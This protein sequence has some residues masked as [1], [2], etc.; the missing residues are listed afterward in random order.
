MAQESNKSVIWT[1]V[2][3]VVLAL[4]LLGGFA[5]VNSNVKDANDKADAAVTAAN[6]A[7]AS[8]DNAV[9]AI[10]NL[11]AASINV[12]TAAEIAAEIDMPETE[13]T[14]EDS[15]ISL[16]KE[17]AIEELLTK[18]WKKTFASKVN[19]YTEAEGIKWSDIRDVSIRDTDVTLYSYNSQHAAVDFVVKVIFD[20]FGDDESMKAEVRC[21]VSGLDRYDNYEDAEVTSCTFTQF[22]SDSY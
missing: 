2:V 3:G 1:V 4:I 13:I 10:A 9:N 7:K 11:P 21:Y 22:I 14:V 15:K 18:D 6:G 8:V 5:M 20:D 19:Q 17:L 16:T 12:P